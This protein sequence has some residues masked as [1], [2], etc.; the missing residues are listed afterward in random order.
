MRIFDSVLHFARNGSG[1]VGMLHA[2]LAGP[3]RLRAGDY[4]VLFTLENNTMR[5]FGVRHRSEAYRR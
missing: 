3:L 2:D 5:I 1:D 4:R